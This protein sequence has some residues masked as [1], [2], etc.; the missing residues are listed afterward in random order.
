MKSFDLLNFK[1]TK[2]PDKFNISQ[3]F[4]NNT[5][6]SY[7]NYKK[8]NKSKVQIDI[9]LF[10]LPRYGINR[11]LPDINISSKKINH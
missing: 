11:L 10:N 2:I 8:I 5:Y 3:V 9:V 4:N 1:L 6:N 7:L